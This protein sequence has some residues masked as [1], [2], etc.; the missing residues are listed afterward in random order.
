MTTATRQFNIG[1]STLRSALFMLMFLGSA[2]MNA[3]FGQTD[4][5]NRDTTFSNISKSP[6]YQLR[7]YDVPKENSDPFHDRFRVHAIRIMKSYGFNIA[8]IW[9]RESEDKHEFVYLLEWEDQKTMKNAWDGFMAD[10]EWADIKL[11]TSRIHGTFVN[12]IKDRTL[13]P[14]DYS[15]AGLV[16]I[17]FE[18]T[19]TAALFA[20]NVVSTRHNQRDFILSP[21]GDEL[22]YVV[23]HPW[24]FS[25]ILHSKKINSLWTRPEVASF[26]GLYSDFEPTF[27]LDGNSVYFSSNRPNENQTKD[28]ITQIWLTNREG[29]TWTEPGKINL[30]AVHN[31]HIF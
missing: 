19:D 13:I 25:T 3:I 8:N 4:L 6:I 23:S 14:T 1:N 30:P 10:Q 24:G 22:F 17:N 26:S 20:E 31:T 2:V 29:T 18:V 11:R 5:S 16:V 28:G 9:I 27:S 12:S 7:I 15:E 21:A